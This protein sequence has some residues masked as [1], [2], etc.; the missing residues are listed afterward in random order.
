MCGIV[1][2]FLK[3]RALEP[4]RKGLA[5][6]ALKRVAAASRISRDCQEIVSRML[7]D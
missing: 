2:L 7:E 3:N 4:K 5:R 1:G 6:A